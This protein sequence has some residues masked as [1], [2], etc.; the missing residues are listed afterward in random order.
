[1]VD[2]NLVD[3]IVDWLQSKSLRLEPHKAIAVTVFSEE[4]RGRDCDTCASRR[5]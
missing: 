5:A 1:M 3:S 4:L 2:V